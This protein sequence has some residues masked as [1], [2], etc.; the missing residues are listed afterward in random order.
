[1][2]YSNA[3][4]LPATAGGFSPLARALNALRNWNDLRE[5]RKALSKLN[6]H[7]LED[8]GLTRGD[9]AALRAGALR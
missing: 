7:M 1:M 4:S 8:I 6:D 3:I 9:V 2:T 5:T